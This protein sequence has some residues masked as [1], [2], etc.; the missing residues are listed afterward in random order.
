VRMIKYAAVFVDGGVVDR[1]DT[2]DMIFESEKDAL[3]DAHGAFV[4]GTG[5]TG[6]DVGLFCEGV[7]CVDV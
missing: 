3:Y 4:G 7:G 6:E 5:T 2:S 1:D